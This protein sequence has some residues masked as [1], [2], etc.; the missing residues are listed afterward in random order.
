MYLLINNI[1]HLHR[2]PLIN[3]LYTD[4][5]SKLL[6]DALRYIWSQQMFTDIQL[7][8]ICKKYL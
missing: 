7:L 3:L 6:Y 8:F 1:Y 2:Y 5:N 4:N